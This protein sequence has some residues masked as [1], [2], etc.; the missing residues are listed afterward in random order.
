MGVQANADDASLVGG[1][2]VT[3][4][5]SAAEDLRERVEHKYANSDGVR[6]HYAMVGDGPLVVMLHGFPDFWYSW[7]KQMR[8]LEGDFRV[9]ALDLRGYNRSGQTARCA[10][11]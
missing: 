4:S 1:L 6:I 7:R 9:A 2:A 8:A 10:G 11:V 5:V 3:A